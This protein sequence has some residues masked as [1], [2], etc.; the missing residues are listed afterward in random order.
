MPLVRRELPTVAAP[1]FRA[2]WFALQPVLCAAAAAADGGEAGSAFHSPYLSLGVAAV[3]FGG[4]RFTD[5][6]DAGAAALYGSGRTFD[7]GSFAESPQALL[8]A[9]V[10]LPS[11]FRLRFEYGLTREFDYSGN[12]NYRNSGSPQPSQALLD[13]RQALLVL[14]RDFPAWEYASGRSLRPFLGI[15]AGISKFRLNDYTQWFPE[16][17]NPQGSLRRGPGGEIPSTALPPGGDR[18]FT[19][20]LTAGVAIPVGENANLDLGY[21]YTDAGEIHTDSGDIKIARYRAN[22]ERREIPVRINETRAD[23]RGHSISLA[24]RFEW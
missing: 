3:S 17:P 14:L 6:A 4:A 10:H 24:L 21:R 11:S 8:A 5:G 7:D 1:L 22:G 15:G 23:L 9:G 16:P 20:M 13:T 2:A 18:E 19:A 12:T